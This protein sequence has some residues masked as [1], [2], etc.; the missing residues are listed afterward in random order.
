[1]N[2]ISFF[3]LNS[4]F[5]FFKGNGNAVFKFTVKI[6]III[7]TYFTTLSGKVKHSVSEGD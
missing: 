1:M 4:L 5:V 2:I 6:Y 7:H 3:I